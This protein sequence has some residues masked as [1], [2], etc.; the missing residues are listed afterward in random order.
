MCDK[1]VHPVN[2]QSG[3]TKAPRP[4][5]ISRRAAMLRRLANPLPDP[6][7]KVSAPVSVPRGRR[8][9]RKRP[10]FDL[11]ARRW[12]YCD[13]D[14]VAIL[15]RF[16]KSHSAPYTTSK[17]RVWR[18][19]PCGMST[20]IARFG[21]LREAL[22]RVGV[23]HVRRRTFPAAE[24]MGILERVWKRLGRAPGPKM[25]RRHGGVTEGPYA[26]RWGSLRAACEALAEFHAGK[27][28]RHELLRPLGP[29]PRAPVSAFVRWSV[30]QRDG[31]RCGACGASPKED[32]RVKL[33]VDHIVPVS[34]GG[35]N[36]EGNLRTLCRACNQGRK[37]RCDQEGFALAR[38]RPGRDDIAGDVQV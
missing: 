36:E 20:I 33:H 37:N 18:E 16:V 6:P 14:L 29:R 26:R 10:A 5:V 30:F 8:A 7:I 23:E 15:A 28:P 17:F 4:R 3:P 13:S 35:S 32:P 19:R 25:L 1:P 34:R 24:L 38:E 11:G 22:A 12:Q 2:A 9:A 27:I 21:S 31:F